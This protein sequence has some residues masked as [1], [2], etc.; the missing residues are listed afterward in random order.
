[1]SR[2]LF[3]TMFAWWVI[4]G[5]VLS[6]CGTPTLAP[7]QEP[8]PVEP[9]TESAAPAA[10]AATNAP[11]P[12]QEPARP[13]TTRKGGWADMLVFTSINEAADA[14]AQMQADAVDIFPYGAEDADAFETAKAVPNLAYTVNYGGSVD[15]YMFNP[16]GPTFNDGRL[17]PF[18]NPRV[19]EALNWLIDRPYL[20]QESVGALANPQWTVLPGAF[21]DY[22]RYVDVIRPL[23]AKYAYNFDKANEAITAEMEAMGA[24][25]GADGKWQ[26][27]GSPVVLIG[28]IR[29]E[30]ER[31]FM[32]NSLA[33]QLEKVGF[34][35]ERQV[36][37]RNQ[38]SP[39]WGRSEPKEGQWHFYTGGWGYN[40]IVRKSANLFDS[41]Y[42]PR[43][44]STTAEQAYVVSP[45]FDQLSMDLANNNYQTMEER[46]QMFA[47][48]LELSMQESQVVW[49]ANISSFYPRR[50]NIVVATDLVAGISIASMYPYTIRRAGEE[51]G[52]IRIANSG[53][54][55]GAWNPLY[56]QNWVQEVV[57]QKTL[58]DDAVLSDPYT[59]LYW[60]QRLEKAEIVAKEGLPIT[61]TLNW[62][63][64]KFASEIQV[65]A[66]AWADWDAANQKF[67]TVGE[68]FPEGATALTK[69]TITYP[70][71]LWDV[72][73]HDG[74]PMSVGDFVLRMILAFDQGKP[75]SPIYDEAAVSN[76]ESLMTY[77]K[78]VKIVSTDPLVIE[79]YLDLFDTDAEVLIGNYSHG[80]WFPINRVNGWAPMSWHGFVPG[81]LAESNKEL[82]ASETK[83][84]AL[85]VNWMHYIDGPSLP[86]LKKYLD[87]AE[88][89]KFIP[90]A[91]TLSQY[92]T[93]EEAVT[94]YA[95][96]QKWYADHNHFWIGTGLYYLD[97]VNSVEGSIV[98]KHNPDFPDLAD[99]W[100]RFGEAMLPVVD[101][102]GPSKLSIGKEASID[103]LV[104]YHDA[105]YPADYMD[106]VLYLFYD[107]EGNLTGKGEA[108]LV[109]EGQ[110]VITLTADLTSSLKEGAAKME[111]VAVS[112]A[113][114]V[115]VLAPI[116]FMVAP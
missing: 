12:T 87:Q 113:V 29:S 15:G 20:A 50:N 63:D 66:D 86:I 68:K 64:L 37:T 88:S 32:G 77:F 40:V 2:K 8:A 41:Y 16:A 65:P 45:E 24:T 1:M 11:A 98:V 114:T 33:D 34:T 6:A 110:Y 3:V 72:K 21:P 70:S 31:E 60:P 111:I 115:P 27:N 79:T 61:K 43:G 38:L 4:A 73:W 92:I 108:A 46:D 58:M 47:R 116:N 26:F 99:K 96:L 76:Y 101:V 44:G 89:E 71:S 97:Q 93:P 7:T 19:R 62:I 90:Y 104:S 14:V 10:P 84:T 102:I 54:L 56:G 91:A 80:T 75:E 109:A 69:A 59:G 55:T 52:T 30:D 112:K 13:T 39:I 83:S 82:A 57:V 42:N 36:R 35:V 106:G 23:E 74:S 51:G 17:N 49:V 81:M 94:R 22:V 25:K 53:I 48:A 95:N 9:T 85:N 5:M 107:A 103:V 67:I 18:S 28:L 100:D 78:G 105:P